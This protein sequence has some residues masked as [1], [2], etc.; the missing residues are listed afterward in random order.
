MSEFNYIEYLRKN[1][2]LTENTIEIDGKEVDKSSLVIG[3]VDKSQGQDD[4][5]AEAYFEEAYFED[6]TPL[7]DS[8]IDKLNDTYPEYAIERALG[9]WENLNE[10]DGTD[11][12]DHASAHLEDIVNQV[13]EILS[14]E[15]S[16]E[17]MDIRSIRKSIF[18][19]VRYE[20]NDKWYKIV[21]IPKSK[22]KE[23]L[24]EDK[25]L[26]EDASTLFREKQMVMRQLLGNMQQIASENPEELTREFLMKLKDV[27]DELMITDF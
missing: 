3:G 14:N 9:S 15:L 26:N 24:N 11:Q 7:N 17:M 27:I 12:D 18:D 8:E 25:E 10:D 5:T 1:P 6:G 13:M 20:M 16:L 19:I 23:D 22:E 21:E 2:L 4:G